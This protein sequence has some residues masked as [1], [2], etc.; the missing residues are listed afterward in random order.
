MNVQNTRKK[1]VVIGGGTG[2][3]TV[4]SGLKHYP[5]D[6]TAVVTMADDGGSTGRLRDEFGV[7]PPGDL[8]QCLVALSEADHVMRK[9]FNHRYDRGE[10]AGHNFGNIF[11][12]TLEQ[13]TGS[14][15]RALDVAGKILNIRGRVIPVTLS[16]VG[17]IAELKNGK[18]LYGESALSDYQLVS[19]FGVEK[20]YLKPKAK[21]NRKAIEAIATADLVVVGPG[22][23]YASLIPNFLVA[24]VGEALSLSKAKRVYVANL[25][26]KNGHTDD[27][28]VSDYVRVLEGAIGKKW[29]FDAVVYNTKKPAQVLLRKYADEGSP[30]VC[31]PECRQ[32]GF[33]LV[34]TDLLANDLAKTAKKD[35]LRRTLIRHDPEKLARVLMQLAV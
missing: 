23:L 12:S 10:L 29:V 33:E 27:F 13:V 1:I 3:F 20:I 22:N 17:L 18:I 19:R 7:L 26:N 31:G 4:L 16:K 32:G 35:F 30:V 25:M 2:T 34:G 11:I 21:A 5:V 14:L 8:R 24:G 15:D 9:L 28:L 6:L